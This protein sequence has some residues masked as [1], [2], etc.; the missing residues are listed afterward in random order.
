MS[1]ITPHF[2]GKAVSGPQSALLT[3]DISAKGIVM[4]CLCRDRRTYNYY[5]GADHR[6]SGTSFFNLPG[7]TMAVKYQELAVYRRVFCDNLMK[8]NYF[9]DFKPLF[10]QRDS[11]FFV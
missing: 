9:Q 7:N 10:A 11:Q 5:I 1:H 8:K 6:C 4:L 2:C 3:T